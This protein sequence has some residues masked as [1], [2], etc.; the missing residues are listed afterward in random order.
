MSDV[1]MATQSNLRPLELSI[2]RLQLI[3]TIMSLL[4]VVLILVSF[5][6]TGF[7]ITRRSPV[8]D[9]PSK[10]AVGSVDKSV[11]PIG[12]D[13]RSIYANYV[14]VTGTPEELV[15]DFGLNTQI[16]QEVQVS[17]IPI[18]QTVVMNFFTAKRFATA[19]QKSVERHEQAFGRIELDIRKRL[20]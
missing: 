1:D 2:K 14:R 20:K 11:T 12:K 3:A 6:V 8:S 16:G 10:P 17:K 9:E 5:V 15:V 4:V 7:L 19:M 13:K 18:Q